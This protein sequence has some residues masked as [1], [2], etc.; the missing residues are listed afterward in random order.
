MGRGQREG[1]ERR[2]R[3]DDKD[4]KG[5]VKTGNTYRCCIQDAIHQAGQG[6]AGGG[7]AIRRAAL[8]A[9]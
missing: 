3:L 6:V 5:I 9:H 1:R 4:E 8:P 2:E 7:G